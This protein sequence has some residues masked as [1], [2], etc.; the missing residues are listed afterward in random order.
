[1]SATPEDDFLELKRRLDDGAEELAKCL[2][3]E[4]TRRR[5]AELRWGR[6]GS[7]QLRRYRDTWRW[8]NF[9]TDEHGSLLDAIAETLGLDFTGAVHWARTWL[10]DDSYTSARKPWRAAATHANVDDD[11]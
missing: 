6:H 4:P 3:G 11:H 7:L 5:K 9:E 8:R 10:D 1:M 2:Y